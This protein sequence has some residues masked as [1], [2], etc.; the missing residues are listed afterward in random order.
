MTRISDAIDWDA[1][2]AIV[3]TKPVS[4]AWRRQCVTRARELAA[5]LREQVEADGELTF[6]RES[7]VDIA[8]VLERLADCTV[9]DAD[10]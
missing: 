2:R 5:A 1:A 7:V 8:I 4:P 3:N 6:T 10:V 9:E